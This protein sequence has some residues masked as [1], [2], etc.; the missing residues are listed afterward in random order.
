MA[1][2]LQA[3]ESDGDGDGGGGEVDGSGRCKRGISRPCK[4]VFSIQ[5]SPWG[6]PTHLGHCA[7]LVGLGVR[8]GFVLRLF[9]LVLVVPGRDFLRAVRDPRRRRRRGSFRLQALPEKAW[10][11][12]AT[13][14]A[15]LSE[16]PLQAYLLCE[17]LQRP[18]PPHRDV[19]L[20]LLIPADGHATVPPPRRRR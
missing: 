7:V 18:R 11:V 3:A 9:F 16:V 19:I 5:A 10:G 1:T 12:G 20:V 13:G 2:H 14:Y 6:A 17:A 15:C 4:R 8:V